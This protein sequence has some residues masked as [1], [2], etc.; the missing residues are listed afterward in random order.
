MNFYNNQTL[1]LMSAEV[2]DYHPR[3]NFAAHRRLVQYISRSL[4]LAYKEVIGMYGGVAEDSV[5]IP[6]DHVDR[7]EHLAS[8]AWNNN[9]ESILV[10]NP[11]RTGYLKYTNGNEQ[12]LGRL[13]ASETKPIG[14][15]Y[16]FDPTTNL[17]Y[18]FGG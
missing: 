8:V 14:D 11:D 5:L 1:I 7:I 17:Y 10:I 12:F 16:T 9:Q 15:A 6:I 4:G 3:E 18:S 13:A 2:A